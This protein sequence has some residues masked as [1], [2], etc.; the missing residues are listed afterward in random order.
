[1]FHLLLN[2]H[3]SLASI[4]ECQWLR[5][6]SHGGMDTL[7]FHPYFHVLCHLFRLSLCCHLQHDNKMYWKIDGK[8]QP[9]LSYHQHTSLTSWTNS[10]KIGVVTFESVHQC[11]CTPVCIQLPIHL[12]SYCNTIKDHVV[13]FLLQGKQVLWRVTSQ[14]SRVHIWLL[15]YTQP[16]IGHT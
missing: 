4:F 3:K 1:M 10:N 7:L 12:Y 2:F 11:V 8:V 16:F 13:F 5:F 6:F 15:T 9:L 14:F